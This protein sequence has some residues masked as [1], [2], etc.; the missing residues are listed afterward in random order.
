MGHSGAVGAQIGRHI[1]VTRPRLQLSQ[2]GDSSFKPQNRKDPCFASS[3][4][5]GM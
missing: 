4:S 1:L 2:R 3:T 5:V